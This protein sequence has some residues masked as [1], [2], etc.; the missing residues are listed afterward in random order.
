M[1][2]YFEQFGEITECTV[3]R[4]NQTGRSRGFGFLTFK[5]PKCV[6]AVMVKE[7]I[8]DGKIVRLL[9][10]TLTYRRLTLNVRFLV[11][12][13]IRLQRSLLEG[14]DR[15]SSKRNSRN[16]LNNLE[17]FLMRR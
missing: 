10:N 14:S 15:M 6:N 3:M 7:H 8:L 11:T 2:A 4:E 1:R 16:I 13:K 9:V 12:N 5:D 17:L